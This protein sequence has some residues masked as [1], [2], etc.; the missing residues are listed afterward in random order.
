MRS[1]A[2]AEMST[3]PP[4]AM[5]A[6]I[7]R[8]GTWVKKPAAAPISRAEP[9]TRPQKPAWSHTGAIRTVH[10]S[11]RRSRQFAKR[12]GHID[13][14]AASQHGQGDTVAR[15]VSIHCLGQC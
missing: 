2:S 15:L 5:T 9:A 7:V 3:P 12:D 10:A 13:L 8:C 14:L 11:R 1:K 4:K 6:A